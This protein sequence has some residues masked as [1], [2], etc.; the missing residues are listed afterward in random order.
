MIRAAIISDTHN[1]LRPDVMGILKECDYIIHDSSGM[2]WPIGIHPAFIP[3]V[4][5]CRAA[6]LSQ[7]FIP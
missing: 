7:Y 3:G 1:V 5:P 4:T 2:I 6:I